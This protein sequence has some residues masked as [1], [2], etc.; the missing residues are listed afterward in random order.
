MH[1]DDKRMLHVLEQQIVANW[2]NLKKDGFQDDSLL[3][4]LN[5]SIIDY[6][7]YKKSIQ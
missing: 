2:E 1:C 4:E 5:E 3:K 7:E 6:N